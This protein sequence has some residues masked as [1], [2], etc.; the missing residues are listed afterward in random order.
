MGWQLW[1]AFGIFLGFAYV[2]SKPSNDQA[3][4]QRQR[5][6]QGRR[7]Y[8]METPAR[9]RLYPRRSPRR[10]DLLLPRITS[11]AHEEGQIP[12]SVQLVQATTTYRS[13][14]RPRYVLRSRT[15]CCRE[16]NHPGKDLHLPVHRVVHHPP[17]PTR[18][19][20]CFCRHVGSTDVWY[21][22]YRLLLK[23]HLP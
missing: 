2:H 10:L 16:P 12:E 17:S 22:Y 6:S 19:L 9:I 11:M 18:Y 1:T 13:Y 3:D 14:R 23:Y 21:Q 8:R 5:S 20:G 7:S 4:Q 15:T